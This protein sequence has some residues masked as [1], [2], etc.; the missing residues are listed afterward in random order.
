MS[1]LIPLVSDP[2]QIELDP[3]TDCATNKMAFDRTYAELPMVECVKAF[4]RPFNCFI[5]ISLYNAATDKSD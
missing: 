4:P 1:I 5:T 3:G 2:T